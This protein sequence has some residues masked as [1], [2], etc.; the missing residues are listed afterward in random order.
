MFSMCYSKQNFKTHIEGGPVL[1][2]D[3]AFVNLADLQR[4]WRRFIGL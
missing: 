4:R 1:H 2:V 3:M